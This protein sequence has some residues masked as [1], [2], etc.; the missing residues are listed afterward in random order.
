M[1][2][3]GRRYRR[4]YGLRPAWI[5]ASGA[6]DPAGGGAAAG[7]PPV[8][9]ETR[10]YALQE[11]LHWG[12]PYVF[13]PLPGL[14]SWAVA[15][16]DG[17]TVRGGLLGGVVRPAGEPL[18][19]A[20][21]ALAAPGLDSPAAR[22]RLARVPVW[23]PARI[24]AAA[25]FLERAFYETSGWTPRL[26][27]ANRLKAAQQRQIAE[28]IAQQKQQGPAAYPIDKE[29]MLLSLIRAGDQNGARRVLNEMLGAMFL[30]SPK[31]PVLRARAIEMMGYLTRAAVEDSPLLEPLI[32][33]NHGWMQRLIA[34]PDFETLAH[35]LMQ[36]LDDFM[37]G[38]YARGFNVY[39]P[40]VARILEFL[41]RDYA[42]P[43]R[44]AE[45]AAHAG[46][47]VFRVSHLVKQATGKTCLEHVMHLRVQKARQLLG[48]STKSC[49]EIAYELGFCDQ[50]YFIK[51]FK[52]LTGT[53]PLRYRRARGAP[54]A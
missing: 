8:P 7:F 12:E 40:A 51:H 21:E 2:A 33:R 38:I 23:P 35:V 34:A 28:A 53:T 46:L 20:R 36:A 10:A 18:E 11:A 41:A 47:S 29:R 32:E 14:V 37:D 3:V 9:A 15:L 16:V 44:L 39:N 22:R 50:S 17:E 13:Y 30:F 5:T 4:A 6:P 25:V 49:S 52:R 42:K 19:T 26:L 45:V 31:L 27:E 54:R 43:V 48:R 1:A 24:R